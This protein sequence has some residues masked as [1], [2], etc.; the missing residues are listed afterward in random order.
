MQRS[1]RAAALT[2]V[3]ALAPVALAGCDDRQAV[4]SFVPPA[5]ALAVTV[6]APPDQARGVPI[7]AEID[8]RVAGG[9]VRGVRLVDSAGAAVPGALRP[10]GTTWVPGRPLAH[11]RT[12]TA[13]VT[14]VA[15]DGRTAEARTRFTTAPRPRAP[16]QGSGLYLFDGNTYGVAMP[17]VAEFLPGVPV[18]DR[19]AVQRR[20]FVTSTPA[21]P[22]VWHW[23]ADGTQAFYRPQTY[24]RP[25]TKLSVR[26]A[27]AGLRLSTGRY[28]ATDR[29]AAVTIGRALS[30]DV[31]NRTKRMTVRRGE[32]VLRTIP[33]SL[34]KPSTPSSSG[35]LVVMEKK[36]STIFD[37]T[38]ELPPG[39][40]YRSRI[41][42][43]QR[44][45][46]GGEFIHAAPWSVGDQ[47]Y[48]NVSH[49]CVNIAPDQAAWLFGQ[50]L[51]GDP[52]TVR[53]TERKVTDGNGWTAWTYSW[54]RFVKGSALPLPP[55]LR[56]TVRTDDPTRS[57]R[58]ITSRL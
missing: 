24:W 51:V 52:V 9:A 31:D 39:E 21:Q 37:T 55:E 50:T 46:W 17:V 36:A 15:G 40:A 34:G 49:G 32:E 44:L 54:E 28:A 22:G 5:A 42:F 10:E 12:Y 14:A 47:G 4:V 11:G 35:V 57:A 29:R 13:V 26:L 20:L 1:R 8:V 16:E 30:M 38:N 56:G 6:T 33:V 58:T 48:R 18:R 53:G 25:G 23:V 2:V 27:L 3:L 43:A 19:A 7:S 41:A 45:T